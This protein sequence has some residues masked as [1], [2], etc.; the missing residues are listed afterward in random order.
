M[1]ANATAEDRQVCLS[2]GMDD[3]LSKPIAISA[4]IQALQ[5]CAP[6]AARGRRRRNPK[7]TMQCCDTSP[8]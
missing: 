8:R 7:W 6:V 4:L 2:A 1:T 3:Y 5:R